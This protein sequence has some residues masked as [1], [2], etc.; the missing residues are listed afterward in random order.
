MSFGLF[1]ICLLAGCAGIIYGARS[2]NKFI[3]I[4]SIII[5]LASAFFIISTML[6]IGGIK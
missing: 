1:S 5:S 6:L 3:L 4:P 2:K